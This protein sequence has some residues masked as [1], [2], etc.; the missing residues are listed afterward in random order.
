MNRYKKELLKKYTPEQIKE[1]EER[2]RQKH[3]EDTTNFPELYSFIYDSSVDIADRKRGVSPLSKS[4]RDYVRKRYE[5]RDYPKRLHALV[6][7][8][9]NLSDPASH[10]APDEKEKD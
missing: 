7:M 4:A 2:H 5:N 1:M 10:N 6:M 8:E 9:L 3:K